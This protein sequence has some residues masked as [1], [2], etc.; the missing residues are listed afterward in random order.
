VVEELGQR[1]AAGLGVV[2]GVGQFLQVFNAAEGLRRAFGFERL[3]VAGAVDEEAD[4]LGQRGGVAGSAEGASAP[5]SFRDF[6]RVPSK[7]GPFGV[8][9]I[10]FRHPETAA[11][12]RGEGRKAA[13]VEQR[14]LVSRCR[15]S[16]SSVADSALAESASRSPRPN[17]S[18]CRRPPRIRAGATSAESLPAKSGSIMACASRMSWRKDS[19]AMSARVGMRRLAMAAPSASQVE[20]PVSR[21]SRSRFPAWFCRCRAPAC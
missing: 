21:A 8:D 1:L 15:R 16:R 12:A 18:R 19:S 17:R 14:K 4:Q 20:T 10:A 13:G 7:S 11:W 6:F 3:D 2:G 9:L 5:S